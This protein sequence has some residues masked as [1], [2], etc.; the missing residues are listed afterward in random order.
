MAD[1]QTLMRLQEVQEE[2]KRLHETCAK[3]QRRMEIQRTVAET[4][5]AH[6]LAECDV[7]IG[8]PVEYE[9]DRLLG[10]KTLMA[11]QELRRLTIL[12]AS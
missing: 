10:E 12:H 2:L 4:L 8:D 11:V 5:L 3:L 1:F 7:A 6:I 9:P